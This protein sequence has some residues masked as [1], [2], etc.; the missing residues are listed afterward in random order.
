MSPGM[1]ADS[2]AEEGEDRFSLEAPEG[3]SPPHSLILA[4]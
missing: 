3:T 2:E 4:Q 1:W